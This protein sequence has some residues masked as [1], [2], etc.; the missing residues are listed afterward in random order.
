MKASHILLLDPDPSRRE[1]LARTLRG[2][3]HQPVVVPDPAAAAQALDVPGLGL[4]ILA[5]GAGGVSPLLL[6][7]A[8]APDEAAPP[9]SLE[10]A[11]R[12]YILRAL[13]YTHGNKRRAAHV[14]GIARSTL[15]AKI[16]RYG[17]ETGTRAE[18]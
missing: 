15:L 3:G 13:A 1:E 16:R 12:S 2:A 9:D 4:V 18:E 14:L 8:L 17:L 11:E 6:R 5:I 7:R 10:A